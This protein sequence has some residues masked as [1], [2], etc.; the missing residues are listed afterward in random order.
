MN[1]KELGKRSLFVSPLGLGCMGFSHAYGKQVDKKEGI[2][3][4]R[5]SVKLGYIF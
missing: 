3:P 5:K 2:D 4:I 1:S